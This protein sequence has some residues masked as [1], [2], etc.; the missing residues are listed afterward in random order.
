[1][2]STFKYLTIGLNT[3]YHYQNDN[4][5]KNFNETFLQN[6]KIP[7]QLH[8]KNDQKSKENDDER[9][10]CITCCE[11]IRNVC[12]QPC[13]HSIMCNTCSIKIKNSSKECPICRT[14][15]SN[16]VIFSLS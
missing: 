12:F 15:I 8:T 3:F 7:T 2:Y 4:D 14:Q 13:R 11:N 6:K 1:M 9:L 5:I 16:Y 10:V